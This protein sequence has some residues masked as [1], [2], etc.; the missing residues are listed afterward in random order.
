MDPE[1]GMLMALIRYVEEL[2]QELAQARE[3]L[4]D[5]TA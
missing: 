5:Y 4:Q 1:Y 2:E 3:D